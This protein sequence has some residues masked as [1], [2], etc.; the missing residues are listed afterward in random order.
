ME[1]RDEISMYAAILG[2]GQYVKVRGNLENGGG[3]CVWA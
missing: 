2:F 1:S 3:P